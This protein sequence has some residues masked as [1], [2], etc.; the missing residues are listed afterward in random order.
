MQPEKA[1]KPITFTLSPIVTVLRA[2]QFKKACPPILVTLS[3]IVID[4]RLVQPLN[5][6]LGISVTLFGIFMLLR[7]VQFSK[8]PIEVILSGSFT[9]STLEPLKPLIAVTLNPLYSAGT[10]TSVTPLSLLYTAVSVL[11]L[12]VLK[13]NTL[14]ISLVSSAAAALVAGRV[15]TATAAD[16]AAKVPAKSIA[17]SFL[18][19]ILNPPFLLRYVIFPAHFP[20]KIK[21]VRSRNHAL[22]KMPAPNCCHTILYSILIFGREKSEH[23]YQYKSVQIKDQDIKLCGTLILPY[24]P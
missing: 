11:S 2:V 8:L 19:F 15:F 3:G 17:L 24:R 12:F 10:T 23:F 18:I 16:V 20:R 6:K 4:P 5:V 7:L 1:L 22:V 13:V 9:V 21:K 14:S